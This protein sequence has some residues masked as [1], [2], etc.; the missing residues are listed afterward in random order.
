MNTPFATELTA[1][2]RAIVTE[3][4]SHPEALEI[5][6]IQWA[7]AAVD[8]GWR[9][10]RADTP[11]MI[12]ERAQTFHHLRELVRLIGANHGYETD[13]DRVGE[14][15]TGEAERYPDFQSRPD[16]P[17][18]RLL[19]KLNR[20]ATMAT[21]HGQVEI[22]TKDFAKDGTPWTAVLVNISQAET[23]QTEQILRDSLKHIWYV[24][25]A[26][27]GRQ[28]RLTVEAS[29]PAEH[30]PETAAGRFAK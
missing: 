18:V 1:L 13:L 19:D 16:W 14:P 3:F 4:V 27:Q 8:I 22:E 12:G 23:P 15:V 24:M 21:R 20:L 6:A 17:R 7:P 25:A 5:T 29:L 10:H 11:R 9:G 30:Q 2:V 28:T 26:A